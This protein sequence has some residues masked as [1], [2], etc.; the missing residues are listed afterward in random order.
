MQRIGGWCWCDTRH[1]CR[2]SLARL[3]GFGVRLTVF[4]KGLPTST[5]GNQ[6]K[7][8][9]NAHG[10]WVFV[11]CLPFAHRN[12]L[13]Q[14]GTSDRKKISVLRPPIGGRLARLVGWL[15]PIATGE[16]L[17]QQSCFIVMAVYALAKHRMHDETA[18]PAQKRDQIRYTIT[19]SYGKPRTGSVGGGA[20]ECPA[21][22]VRRAWRPPLPPVPRT[23]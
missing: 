9:C 12:K 22:P 11:T 1:H 19:L 3:A 2:D 18:F 20:S 15:N 21:V 23:R 6:G 5:G 4:L 17:S 16:G 10:Y 14:S 8:L 13:I 7:T